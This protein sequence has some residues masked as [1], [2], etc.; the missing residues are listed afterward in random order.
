MEMDILLQQ[1]ELFIQ[2]VFDVFIQIGLFIGK[3]GRLTHCVMVAG[4]SG[5]GS[6]LGGPIKFAI[7]PI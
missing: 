2:K 7:E 4:Q 3:A 5:K 1:P 6:K